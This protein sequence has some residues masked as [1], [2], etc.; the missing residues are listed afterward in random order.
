M[1]LCKPCKGAPHGSMMLLFQCVPEKVNTPPWKVYSLDPPY[2][3]GNSSLALYFFEIP[4]SP[5]EFLSNFLVVGMDIFWNCTTFSDF[6]ASHVLCNRRCFKLFFPLFLQVE[7]YKKKLSVADFKSKIG[8][9]VIQLKIPVQVGF[10]KVRHTLLVCW[11]MNQDKYLCWDMVGKNIG[12][13]KTKHN[14]LPVCARLLMGKTISGNMLPF[15]SR[16]NY[17]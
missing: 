12:W 8:Q 13:W 5:L 1:F 6:S 3:W 15:K 4:P 14:G 10:H 9:I 17:Y 7:I 2:P 16:V 11:I